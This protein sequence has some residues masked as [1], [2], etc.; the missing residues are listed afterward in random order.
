MPEYNILITIWLEIYKAVLSKTIYNSPNY[1][2]K[3]FRTNNNT[4]GYT[5]QNVTNIKNKIINK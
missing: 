3:Y 4:N 5:L 2:S 1:S